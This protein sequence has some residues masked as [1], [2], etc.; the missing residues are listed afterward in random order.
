MWW[1]RI[2][3]QIVD[4]TTQKV[5]AL[6]AH[7]RNRDQDASQSQNCFGA[8]PARDCLKF[9]QDSQS[10][11]R[12]RASQVQL[13]GERFSKSSINEAGMAYLS[14]KSKKDDAFTHRP[15]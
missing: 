11:K 4:K 1:T 7:L 12:H 2:V 6:R 14:A 10:G 3:P 5:V 9:E 13:R 8:R 15:F